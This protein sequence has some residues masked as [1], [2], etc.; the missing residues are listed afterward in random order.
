LPTLN[1]SLIFK[2][3]RKIKK[4]RATNLKTQPQIRGIV[5][6]LRIQTPKK[7]N[8]ARRPVVK[9]GLR[10][11]NRVI[12]HIPGLGHNLR[13]HSEVLLGGVG[14]KD[15]PGI[16]YTCIKGVYD[17]AGSLKKLKRRSIYGTKLPNRF[18]K[19]LRRKFRI[20]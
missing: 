2:K 4:N 9:V 19:K 14:C 6:K 11:M 8:S 3:T 12:A 20:I 16:N 1:Q 10:N 15:L 13:K 17:F 7:P 5:M 18:K